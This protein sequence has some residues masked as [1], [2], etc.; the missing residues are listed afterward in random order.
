[1]IGLTQGQARD[2]A[3]AIVH[4]GLQV[5]ELQHLSATGAEIEAI[6]EKMLEIIKT[7]FHGAFATVQQDNNAEP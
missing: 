6:R 4:I 7:A 2:V 5:R 1:M 3:Y